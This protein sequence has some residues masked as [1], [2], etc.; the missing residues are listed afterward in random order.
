MRAIF[1]RAATQDLRELRRYL[2]PLSPSGL[3]AVTSAI[4]RR[5]Q[6]TLEHPDSGRPSP[7]PAIRESIEPRYGF[8][9]PYVV[10]GEYLIVL[11]IYRSARKPLD[12]EALA[13][14]LPRND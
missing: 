1:S 4:E 3:A 14:S 10:R 12:Y 13:K 8:L 5:V 9:I 11:R 6:V 2:S 7:H